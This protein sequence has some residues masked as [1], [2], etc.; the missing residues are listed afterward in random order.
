M[1]VQFPDA[2]ERAAAPNCSQGRGRA[3][4][5]SRQWAKISERVSE[6]LEQGRRRPEG[7]RGSA[8]TARSVVH[9]RQK[10]RPCPAASRPEVRRVRRTRGSNCV[11]HKWRQAEINNGVEYPQGLS[12]S[13][14]HHMN[15]AVHHVN[16]ALPRPLGA[17]FTT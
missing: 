6:A 11:A 13:H 1:I 8:P 3:S 14:V 7:I 15:H 9:L 10:Y 16:Q 5:I 12:K 17:M 4:R 2:T